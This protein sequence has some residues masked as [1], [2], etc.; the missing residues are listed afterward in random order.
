MF[1][2]PE[3]FSNKYNYN[4]KTDLYSLGIILYM[5]HFGKF[6]Y[7]V[8]VEHTIKDVRE[9]VL[10]QKFT[11]MTDLEP[12]FSD[13]LK[14]LLSFQPCKRS[15]VDSLLRHPFVLRCE[16]KKV[17]ILNDNPELQ[18]LLNFNALQLFSNFIG[19]NAKL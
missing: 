13:L 2:S 16:N 7:K 8:T 14:T 5:L 10:K 17:S 11:D 4:E 19:I 3:S 9:M 18:R 15:D 1:M 12:D 6:P